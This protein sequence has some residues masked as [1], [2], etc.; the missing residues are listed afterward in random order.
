MIASNDDL[1]TVVVGLTLIRETAVDEGR[2]I[3]FMGND[4]RVYETPSMIADVE[5]ACRDLLF[6]NLPEG[7][8]SVGTLVDM[9]HLAPT[10]LN[11]V[12]TIKVIIDQIDGRR[13]RFTCMVRDAEEL[14]GDGIHDR[15][16]VD[17]DRH[18]NR[19]R[20]KQARVN[21]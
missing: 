20:K 7:K 11:A 14:V 2:V 18:R 10:P 16:I 4:L 19:V 3:T 17:V 9:K 13:V 6:D 5:Y 15:V 12:V 1:G 21:S 8:D